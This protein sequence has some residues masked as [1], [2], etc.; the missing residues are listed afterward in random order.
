LLRS[1]PKQSLHHFPCPM[2]LAYVEKK[3]W[4]DIDRR[5]ALT[6]TTQ[7]SGSTDCPKGIE[8]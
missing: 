4:R 7:Y 8:Q 1:F 6:Q 3:G 5:I 2:L